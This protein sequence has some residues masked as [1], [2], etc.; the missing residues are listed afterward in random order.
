MTATITP[1]SAETVEEFSGRIFMEGLGA[2]HLGSVYLGVKLGLFRTLSGAGPI[3]ASDLAGKLGLDAWYVREWLLAEATAGLVLADDDDLTVAQFRLAP[4]VDE[5]L[6]QET[7]PAY[8]GGLSY[9]LSALGSVFP[10]LV[11]AFRT[12]SGVAYSAYGED[13]V[14]AQA[15]INRPAFANDLVESWLPSIPD[16]HARLSDTARPA[17]VA[18]V[19]CGVGWAAIELAKAFPHVRIDGYDSDEESITRARHN[20]AENGVADRV[21]FQV[22]D[23]ASGGYGEHTYDAIFFFECLHDMAHPTDALAAAR[24]ALAEGGSVIVMDERVAESLTPGDPTETFFAVASVLWCLP[25]GRV[26]P[27]SETPGP[28]MRPAMF[29]A[30]AQRAGFTGV[31]ILGIEHPFWRFYRP[32]VG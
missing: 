20:A 25:Q 29:E 2:L 14:T 9:C 16:L 31:E 18:D 10:D 28:V 26:D 24:A 15:A 1:T 7:H 22:V 30:I 32:F 12:G 13:A 21:T 11:T 19:G 6:V 5:V 23:A 3:G 4:G 8:L 27:T 17:R